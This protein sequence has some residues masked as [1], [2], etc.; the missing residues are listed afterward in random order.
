MHYPLYTTHTILIH[1]RPVAALPLYQ[2]LETAGLADEGGAAGLAGAGGAR[3]AGGGGGAA[4]VAGGGFTGG[5][6]GASMGPTLNNG[7]PF[8]SGNN[9]SNESLFETRPEY[10]E[11]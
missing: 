11:L 10:N 9:N 8:N 7:A 4:G 2:S 1:C 3:L 5:G 6:A